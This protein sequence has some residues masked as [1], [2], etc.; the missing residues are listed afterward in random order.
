VHLPGLYAQTADAPMSAVVRAA[1]DGLE[2]TSTGVLAGPSPSSPSSTSTRSPGKLPSLVADPHG[3]CGREKRPPG[4]G[5]MEGN[6]LR[7]RSSRT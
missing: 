7:V 5:R 2:I 3:Q 1:Y 6:P 4:S